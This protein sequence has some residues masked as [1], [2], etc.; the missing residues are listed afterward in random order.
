MAISRQNSRSTSRRCD[1]APGDFIGDRPREIVNEELVVVQGS[2]TR[3]PEQDP[4]PL[5]ALS[6]LKLALP[7]RRHG[8]RI[9]IE[10]VLQGYSADL[11]PRLEVDDLTVIEDFVRRT[12]W[13]TIL[14]ETLVQRGLREGALRV[15]KLAPPGIFRRMICVRDR[16]RPESAAEFMLI[17]VLARKLSELQRSVTL[18][19]TPKGSMD[20]H[21]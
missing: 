14:P 17:D 6:G 13:V 16:R 10:D 20:V 15:R 11:Q 1:G 8:L 9:A 3:L 21:D 7:S 5:Y 12:D 4:V 2:Q 18:Y 19:E